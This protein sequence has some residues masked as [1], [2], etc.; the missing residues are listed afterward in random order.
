MK[1][2]L[3]II[4]LV[5][6]FS[7]L[8]AQNDI[9]VEYIGI[10]ITNNLALKQKEFSLQKSLAALD[11]AEGMFFPS[12]DISAR[13]TRAEGGRMIELP[14]GDLMNPV[15]SGLN[16]ILG[17]DLY[18]QIPNQ[19]I[20]F[21]REKEHDTKISLVQPIF[22]PQI[23]FNYQIKSDLAEITKAERLLYQ[24]ELIADIKKAYYNYN[25]ACLALDIYEEAIELLKEN[26]RVS[27][28]L[29]QNQKVTKDFV[30]RAETELSEVEQKK[31][32]AANN[33][34]L[35]KNYFN[36]ILN[37]PLDTEIIV[38]DENVSEIPFCLSLE[39]VTK[40]ALQEREEFLQ[41]SKAIEI[42]DESVSLANSNS[43]PSILFAADYGYQGEEYDFNNKND[44][45]MASLV[46]KWNLFKG[47]QDKGR[48]EQS[49]YEKNILETKY[50]ELQKKIVLQIS[51]TYH[52]YE[53]IKQS[54]ETAKL[55]EKSSAAVFKIVQKK[56][57]E[58]MA[59]QIEYI[60]AR[61]SLTRSRLNKVI[62]TFDLL[63]K[64]SELEKL[65]VTDK[66]DNYL[67][68][69]NPEN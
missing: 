15:Y 52:H 16:Q 33:K 56:Y 65:T 36:F 12:I 23:F 59:S 40:K 41:I 61:A 32:E 24:R 11:E 9:L 21:L 57:A 7:T 29:Y 39:E 37:R 42:A 69:R 50:L 26:L 19:Q 43:L 63:I 54:L 4:I 18:P 64:I 48:A 55:R 30:Y 14:V 66:V 1:Y 49:E 10:G 17:S 67:Q 6:L 20:N 35:A 5:G 27:N 45:W 38:T 53:T 46:L 34:D 44:Y 22:Q 47:F 68:Q 13:Y 62:T 60:D 31:C 2:N 25:K 8:S 58:G 51:D 3:F 28:S